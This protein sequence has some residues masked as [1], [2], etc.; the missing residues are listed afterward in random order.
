MFGNF[1]QVHKATTILQQISAL[2]Y[3]SGN[4]DSQSPLNSLTLQGWLVSAVSI[5]STW[6]LSSSLLLKL[7]YLKFFL[8]A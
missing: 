4:V 7:L 6:L 8:R 3:F 1:T 5:T 2:C